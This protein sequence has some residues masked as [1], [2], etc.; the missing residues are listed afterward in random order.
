[1]DSIFLKNMSQ[2]EELINK[3]YDVK[4]KK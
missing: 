2:F 4:V 1:M 3:A